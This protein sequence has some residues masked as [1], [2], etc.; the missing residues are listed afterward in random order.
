MDPSESDYERMRRENIAANERV[1]AGLGLDVASA[2]LKPERKERS[3]R[4]EREPAT[5]M[6]TSLRTAGV[7]ADAS[8]DVVAATVAEAAMSVLGD[9]AA[10]GSSEPR[11]LK[12]TSGKGVT[13]SEEQRSDLL[14]A[15]GWVG[16]MREYLAGKVSESN[17]ELTMKRVEEV[18][19]RRGNSSHFG[20]Q[21]VPPLVSL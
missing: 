18:R 20:P 6:R 5:K 9:G 15:T 12:Q 16:Q 17:L 10:S 19:C 7:D 21:V 3:E 14:S 8:E 4:K 1:L 11:Q 13:L 2:R